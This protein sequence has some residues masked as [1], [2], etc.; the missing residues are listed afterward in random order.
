LDGVSIVPAALGSHSGFVEVNAET[1][2]WGAKTKRSEN[3]V[4]PIITMSDAFSR[5]KAGTP[6][7]A[8]I[9]IEGFESDLF[10]DNL[11]WLDEVHMLIVEPHD[12]LFPGQRTSRSLQTAIASRDFE[13]FISGENLVYLR[14]T[15]Q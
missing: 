4:I 9:D 1:Y 14:T 13:I 10:A 12:W 2:S 7:L 15:N 11:S 6:F 3:G 5:V 8:K